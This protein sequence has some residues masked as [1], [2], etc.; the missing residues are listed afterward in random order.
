MR[1]LLVL[2]AVLTARSALGDSV[3]VEVSSRVLAED[4]DVQVTFT[5]EGQGEGTIPDL[6]D[7]NIAGQ[8]QSTSVRIVNGDMKRTTSQTYVL[9]PKKQGNLTIASAAISRGGQVVAQSQPVQI[10]VRGSAALKPSEALAQRGG[11][12]IEFVTEISR[13]HVYVGEPF[14][15]TAV[16]YV[17]AKINDLDLSLAEVELP[18]SVQRQDVMGPTERV[19]GEGQREFKGRSYSRF[20]VFQ[21]AWQVLRPEA[22]L[23]VPGLRATLQLQTRRSI[24]G[25][26]F[27]VKAAPLSLE[28]RSVPS[29]GRPAGY[30]EGAIGQFQ[31]TA[32]LVPDQARS[33]AVFEIVIAGQ[34]SLKTLDP[35]KIPGVAGARIEPLP[36]DERDKFT[37][38]ADGVTGQRV[39]QYLVTPQR[40]GAVQIPAIEYA[41]FDPD[42]E[43]F[44]S[45][46]TEAQQY[47]ASE[48]VAAAPTDPERPTLRAEPLQPI[49]TAVAIAEPA[50]P[51]LHRRLWFQI[52]LAGPLGLFFA[53]ELFAFFRR[54][55]QGASG[56][57]RVRRA[58]AAAQ[59]RL[60][61]LRAED[62]AAFFAGVAGALRGYLDARFG[63]AAAGLTQDAL[64]AALASRGQKAATI[65]SLVA[66]LEACDSARFSPLAGDAAAAEAMRKRAGELVAA[67]EAGR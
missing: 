67:M 12:D 55:S 10:M 46:Q 48:G 34:G 35:P 59:H 29:A 7:W 62:G 37:P 15:V 39:F 22:S 44:A 19:R 57:N 42:A 51:A 1:G 28:V 45:A 60:S 49:E 24:F 50:P 58:Q 47:E 63:F 5:F 11:E 6:S 43:K 4:D 64:R 54:R 41:W 13:D 25:E 23:T 52:G 61:E 3:T 56:K 31:V 17:A 8:N 38:T 30:R 16:V 40:A 18:D 26:Q 27:R 53:A 36:S 32:S 20:V 66:E 21:E 9:T 33:R 65:E 14:I 2:L